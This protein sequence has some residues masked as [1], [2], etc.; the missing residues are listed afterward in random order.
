MCFPRVLPTGTSGLTYPFPPVRMCLQMYRFLMMPSLFAEW[1]LG[2]NDSVGRSS[3]E[4]NF[5][6]AR[7]WM[8]KFSLVATLPRLDSIN[9]PGS[10][11]SL[12]KAAGV[13]WT[14]PETVCSAGRDD[15]CLCPEGRR[16]LCR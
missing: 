11:G 3:D 8:K 2:A 4:V 13:A 6:W 15:S 16:H 1:N 7:L 10:E 9:L 14:L 12:T 5:I